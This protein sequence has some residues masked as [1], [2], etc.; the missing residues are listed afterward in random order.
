M[1]L[2]DRPR[3]VPDAVSTAVG[4]EEVIVHAGQGMVRV[5]NGVG[6]RLWSLAD[7]RR[8]IGDMASQIAVE[9][10]V[11]PERARADALAFCMELVTRGLLIVDNRGEA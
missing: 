8:S 11:T 5:V 7:G 1:L 10:E 3:H 6:A 9:Y 2:D 4:E